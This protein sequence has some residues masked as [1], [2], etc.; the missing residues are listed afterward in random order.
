MRV[1]ITLVP[2]RKTQQDLSIGFGINAEN[3]LCDQQKLMIH[4]RF[5]HHGESAQINSIYEF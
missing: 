4:A 5:V 1:C 3:K 2:L